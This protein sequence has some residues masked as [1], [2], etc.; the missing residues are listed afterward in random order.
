MSLM[1]IFGVG[2]PLLIILVMAG[3]FISGSD[4]TLLDKA[5]GEFS[6]KDSA[7][8]RYLRNA[9]SLLLNSPAALSSNVKSEPDINIPAITRM[10]NKGRPT[11]KIIINDIRS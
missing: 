9:E 2:L 1:I 6:N 11:P 10:I 8:L 3:M 5:A 7:F 4:L